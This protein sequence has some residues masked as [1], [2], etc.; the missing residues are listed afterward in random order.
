MRI[1]LL[2]LL[3]INIGVAEDKPVFAYA[4]AGK[5][6]S[7]PYDHGN[8]PNFKI[9]WWYLT[10][11]LYSGEK[12][13]GFESTFF[14]LAQRP[15]VAQPTGAAFETDQIY[16][17]H[18]AIT[19]LNKKTFYHEERLNR[20]GWN[21]YSKVGDLDTRNGNWA[22]KRSSD[23][24]LNLEG[25]VQSKVRFSL[26]LNPEKEHVIFGE[27]GVSKKGSKPGSASYYITWPR[28][29]TS[30]TVQ[31][32]GE[33]F[34]VEGSSW[35]DHEISSSQLDDD[36]T[37]WDWVSIQFEDGREMMA[38]M[39]RLKQGGYSKYSKMVWIDKD[40]TLTHQDPKDFSWQPDGVW[41]S[42]DTGAKYPINPS[43]T[44]IDPQTQKKVTFEVRPLMKEQEMS[45][46]LGGV[47]YWEGACDVIDQAGKKV[48][49][50]YLELAG[51][52]DGLN[53]RLR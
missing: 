16:M 27:N 9:E 7:F 31:I 37:G 45:G 30:G 53:E 25:S 3:L 40:G 52:V 36:Q 42:P 23:N 32:N 18:M 38:Y 26:I 33:T 29:K 1:L 8:H 39:L 6:L 2:I 10:G 34:Q 17:A 49:V 48:G 43:F 12:R 15:D 14:R 21:A 13:F 51:Y 4:K 20:Q 24:V 19:D 5:A 22:L 28:L 41:T 44:T 46:K 11:H 47:P 50:A 35:M